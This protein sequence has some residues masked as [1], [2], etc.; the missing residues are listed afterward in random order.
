MLVAAPF[1]GYALLTEVNNLLFTLFLYHF[2]T[3]KCHEMTR[4]QIGDI[5]DRISINNSVTS[6]LFWCRSKQF[7]G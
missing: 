2:K 3:E 5:D 1:L 6:R 4:Q 7:C